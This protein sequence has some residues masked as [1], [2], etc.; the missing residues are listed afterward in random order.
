MLFRIFL[1]LPKSRLFYLLS[2]NTI[3]GH[4]VEDVATT[5]V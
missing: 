1:C 5:L 2:N 4:E 3:A